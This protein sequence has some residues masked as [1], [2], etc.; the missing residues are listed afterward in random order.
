MNSEVNGHVAAGHQLVVYVVSG[1]D[2]QSTYRILQS[3]NK[4]LLS[5]LA[6]MP[7]PFGS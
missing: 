7:S 5:C 4:M 2:S 6:S 3:I 1:G